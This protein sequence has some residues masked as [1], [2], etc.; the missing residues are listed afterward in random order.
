MSSIDKP[1][2]WDKAPLSSASPAS[3]R[4]EP[5]MT[6]GAPVPP[7]PPSS[8]DKPQS[9]QRRADAAPAPRLEGFGLAVFQ[10][11]NRYLSEP[12]AKALLSATAAAAGVPLVA[13]ASDHLALIVTQIEKTFDIFGVRLDAKLTCLA[14]IRSLARASATRGDVT[15][16]ILRE[17][18][19]VLA[20]TAGRDICRDIG[21]TEVAYVKVATAI[22][23]LARNIIKYA[24]RGAV[25]LRILGGDRKGIEIV[26]ADQGPGI[27]D[28]EAVLSPRYRSRSGMGVGMRGTRQLMDHFEVKSTVGQGTTVTIRKFKN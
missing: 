18:D 16:P 11:L 6:G 19:I 24:N 27:P 5:V 23:E 10:E 13:L 1:W 4:R 7:L 15:I 28:I 8:T 12:N 17:D 9:S 14:G 26:V 2:S 20:R 22:S 3:S 21:F 25:T